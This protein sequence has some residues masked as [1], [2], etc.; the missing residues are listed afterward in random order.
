LHS[1]DVLILNGDEVGALLDG[2]ERLVLDATRRAYEAHGRAESSLPH[3]TFLTFPGESKNRIIALPAY[4]GGEF[5]VCGV[6]WVASFPA[7]VGR[8]M[9]RASATIIL[10]SAETGRTEAIIE[11]SL[12]SAKRTAA[13]AALAAR[14]LHAD[15]GVASVGMV[16]AGLINFEIA[17]Y[18][19]C[20]F[21]SLRRFRVFDLSGERAAHF[22]RRCAEAFGGVTVEPA[23]DLA[24]VLESS[25]VVSFA[26]TAS[27]PHVR[28]LAACPPG[29]TLLHVSLRDLA[30]EV[31]LACDNV[32]DDVDHVCRARTSVHLA[33]QLTGGRD[34][35][36]CTLADVL[37]RR[38][39]PRRSAD[40]VTVFSPFGLGVLD[41]A[42]ASLVY[43][44]GR[45]QNVGARIRSFLPES[46]SQGA[47]E[48]PRPLLV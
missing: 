24:S 20:V 28:D 16:G 2:R 30:P 6:K 19:L 9:D 23:R 38:A 3:S 12:I 22:A 7:N 36:R 4:L 34:F 10:N 11:G 5:G 17:R 42:V 25:P 41:M 8:G 35:I 29:A 37:E 31:V 21:P 26:T 1:N 39:A 44:L 43:R 48:R 46:W 40:G 32:V 47:E 33:E 13:S 18:L 14:A 27:D 45:E 15:A